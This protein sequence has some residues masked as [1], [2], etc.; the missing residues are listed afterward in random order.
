MKISGVF[1]G[2]AI[3][4]GI[5]IAIRPNG[6]RILLNRGNTNGSAIVG[7]VDN[8]CRPSGK[9]VR[10]SNRAIHVPGIRTTHGLNV[11]MVRRRLG[12]IPRLSV[13]RGLFLNTLPAGINFVGGDTVGD[14]TH[15]TL[16]L[17]N[18]GRSISAPVNRLN[19]THRRVIRVTGTLVRSTSVL[20]LSRPATTLAHG[21]Y[22]R[23]FIVVKRLGTEN[24]NVMFVSRRLSRVT[25]INS[26]IAILH[27]NGCVSAVSTGTPRSRLIQL[28][29][30]HSVRGR[31][32]QITRRPNGALLRIG[33]LAHTKTVRRISF[34]IRTNRIIN[35]TKLINTNHARILHTI[36]NTSSCSS[37]SIAISNIRLPGT[38]VSGAVTTKIKLIPRSHHARNLVLRTSITSGLNL[39]AV[40]PASGFKFTSLG[41]RHSHRGSATEGLH[42]HVTGVSRATNSLSNN[43]RRGV[44]FNG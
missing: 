12:V 27:S 24:I 4:S 7:V 15:R 28:V 37:N 1:N 33:S 35:L 6:I 40:I 18:L 30:K 25:H 38:S 36:F 3:I 39:T 8:V 14:G 41:K 11:T 22:R 29:I 17:V 43:G 34:S 2:S 16:G 9:R 19:I 21:R 13:V 5:S 26:I 23:L 44:I 42:V 10:I 32:P 31:C 20:V